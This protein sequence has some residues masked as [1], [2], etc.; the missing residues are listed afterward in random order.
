MQAKG[1]GRGWTRGEGYY[2]GEQ[3]SAPLEQTGF[4]INYGDGDNFV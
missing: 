1:T 3:F 4:R 2:A